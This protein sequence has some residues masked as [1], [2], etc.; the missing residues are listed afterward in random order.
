M[1]EALRSP[2]LPPPSALAAPLSDSQLSDKSDE[3]RV[4]GAAVEARP[5]SNGIDGGGGGGTEEA[6]QVEARP[7]GHDRRRAERGWEH[8][9]AKEDEE[10]VGEGERKRESVYERWASVG[11]AVGRDSDGGGGGGGGRGRA[12]PMLWPPPKSCTVLG[13]QVCRIPSQ[14]VVRVRLSDRE[15]LEEF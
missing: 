5:L 6:L 2:P 7:D 11:T 13:D 9:A 15:R 10:D 3:T 1:S 14:V 8:D 4:P 12:L